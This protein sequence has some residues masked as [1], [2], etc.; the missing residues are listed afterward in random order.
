[1]FASFVE[2]T[3]EEDD[4]TKRDTIDEAL[5]QG[6]NKEDSGHPQRSQLVLDI[7]K[8]PL[9]MRSANEDYNLNV[10]SE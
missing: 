3:V 2:K 1:M 6:V 7:L 5:F 10:I 4:N 8:T 9:P